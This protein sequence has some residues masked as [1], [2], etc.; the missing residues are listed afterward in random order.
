MAGLKASFKLKDKHTFIV[1]NVPLPSFLTGLSLKPEP[2]LG[3]FD[4]IKQP[5]LIPLAVKSNQLYWAE[6]LW[7][8]VNSFQAGQELHYV[9]KARKPIN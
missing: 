6:P 2:A 1:P 5:S 9:L 8:K 7:R 4:L 3:N